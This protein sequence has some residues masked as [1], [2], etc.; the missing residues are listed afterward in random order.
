MSGTN[1][2]V[3]LVVFDCG[4]TVYIVLLYVHGMN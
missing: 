4:H 2:T 1:S 3:S